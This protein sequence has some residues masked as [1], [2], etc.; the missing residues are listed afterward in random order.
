MA[1]SEPKDNSDA[2]LTELAAISAKLLKLDPVPERLEAMEA[3]LSSLSEENTA[4]NREVCLR[5]AEISGLHHRLYAVEQYNR[6]W[7]IH[8]NKITI[9]PED[10]TNTRK[11]MEAIY[12]KLVHPILSGAL[13]KGTINTI[14]TLHY[15]IETA[16]ILPGKPNT[17][18]PIIVRFISLH[19]KLT[20]FLFKKE[21]SPKVPTPSTSLSSPSH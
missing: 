14:P 1:P 4:L 21:C 17:A 6:A 2:I 8:F 11:A 9:L 20:L 15:A 5:D 16:H 19:L 12:T 18:K 13:Q 3:L 7:S 10:E